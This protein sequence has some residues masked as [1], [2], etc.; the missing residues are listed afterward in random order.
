MKTKHELIGKTRIGRLLEIMTTIL[1]MAIVLMAPGCKKDDASSPGNEQVKKDTEILV[2]FN[3]VKQGVMIDLMKTMTNDYTKK[4]G[5]ANYTKEQLDKMYKDLYAL[6]AYEKDVI[7][8]AGRMDDQLSSGV[9]GKIVQTRGLAGKL[10]EFFGWM[11]GSS[12]RSRERILTVASNL[13]E[14]E[15]KELY[16]GLSP[17]LKGKAS[18]EGDFWKKLNDGQLDNSAARIYN[19]FYHNPYSNFN[20][21]AQDKNLT[22]GKVFVN[23]GAE[24]VTKGA[25][26]I[27]EVT[28]VAAPGLGKGIELVEKGQEYAEKIE[29][30]YKDPKQFIKNEVKEQIADYLGGF[31]DIDGAVDAGKLSEAAGAAIK[32]LTDY[33]LGSD[34]PADWVKSAIDYGLA[35]ILDGN[36]ADKA[37]VAIAVKA[38]NNKNQTGPNVVISVDPTKDDKDLEDV[39]D[40][41]LPGGDWVISPVN[42]K[43]YTDKIIAEV[44]EEIASVIPV[45]TDPNAP[46]VNGQ[47]ALS[48]WISPADPGPGE[49]V[50]VTAK[51][52][53]AKSGEDIYFSIT[54]TDG[55]SSSSTNKTDNEGKATFYIPGGAGGVRDEVHIKIVS[56][57]TERVIVYT[58]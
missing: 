49:G 24:G 30:V 52:S 1:M 20:D 47:Y 33:T 42:I 58:F 27:I 9:Q 53:P 7:A 23:E 46:H 38:D 44:I 6:Q 39:I 26:V 51:I 55:Y 10:G 31:V 40:I 17:E 13:T 32:I 35:K 19:D 29:T 25:E 41:M 45:N 37:N 50:T 12:K 15:R 14:G 5:K 16:D 4:I 3:A 54:G 28:K 34:D 8:A 43:G 48:V 57:G 36:T 11:S 18:S 2:E 56:T 22:I 21:V